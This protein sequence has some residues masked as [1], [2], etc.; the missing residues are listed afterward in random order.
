MFGGGSD[1]DIAFGETKDIV[2]LKTQAEISLKI[3]LGKS[4]GSR[5]G[6]VRAGKHRGPCCLGCLTHSVFLQAGILEMS[7]KACGRLDDAEE[8]RTAAEEFAVVDFTNLCDLA[9]LAPEVVLAKTKATIDK[10]RQVAAAQKARREAGA[11]RSGAEQRRQ[12]GPKSST[13]GANR[14]PRQKRPSTQSK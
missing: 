3:R 4:E 2:G 7:V 9:T 13:P 1:K 11:A 12:R 8:L 6:D 10:V 14:S 5:K